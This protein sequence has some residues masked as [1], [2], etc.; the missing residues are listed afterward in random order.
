MQKEKMDV[1]GKYSSIGK[2]AVYRIGCP[3]SD[4]KHKIK[5]AWWHVLAHRV[6][7]R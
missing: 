7:A 2:V 4:L 1:L 6:K 3:G 5:W